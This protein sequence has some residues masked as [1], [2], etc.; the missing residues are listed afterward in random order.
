MHG[1]QVFKSNL[2]RGSPVTHAICG[3]TGKTPYGQTTGK[4]TKKYKDVRKF[5]IPIFDES[6]ANSV[7]EK[8]R[9][10]GKTLIEQ[11]KEDSEDSEES[12]NE[13]DKEDEQEEAESTS[14]SGDE[15]DL[16]KCTI[17]ELKEKLRSRGL[18]VSGAKAVLIERLTSGDSG[19]KKR[20]ASDAASSRPS[21]RAK[22]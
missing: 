22:K 3:K 8:F 5:K 7:I 16:S 10:T 12:D 1:A 17:P 21:K 18:P 4:G 6:W 2:S 14:E 13:S 20:K 9:Q 15:E 19:T 11:E